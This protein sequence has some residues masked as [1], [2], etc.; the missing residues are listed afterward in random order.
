LGTW[1]G[2]IGAA[3]GAFFGSAPGAAVGGAGGAVVGSSIGAGIEKSGQ[4]KLDKL[5]FQKPGQA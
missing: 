1:I 3:V 4:K 2:G 5:K